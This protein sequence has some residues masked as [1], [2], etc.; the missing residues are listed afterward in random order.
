MPTRADQP[1]NAPRINMAFM[2]SPVR[3]E[4]VAFPVWST[5]RRSH[6]FP[7]ESYCCVNLTVTVVT[8]AVGTPFSSV[9]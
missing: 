9:G 7:R 3:R 8:T 1:R 5:N 2:R 4:C 6:A